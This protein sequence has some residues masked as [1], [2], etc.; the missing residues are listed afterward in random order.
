MLAARKR[1]GMILLGILTILS[2][3]PALL[4]Y[5]RRYVLLP[6]LENM[7]SLI[8]G[9]LLSIWQG[10]LWEYIGS[11]VI[12]LADIKPV[13]ELLWSNYS[14]YLISIP[15]LFIVMHRSGSKTMG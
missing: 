6:F 2:L 9:L 13:I 7:P 8:S 14:W 5:I 1:W 10:N 3:V 4:I 11:K 15:V 12:F